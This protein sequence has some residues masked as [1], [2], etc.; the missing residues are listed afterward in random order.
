MRGGTAACQGL[1]EQL[2][3]R[4]GEGLASYEAHRLAVDTYSLQHPERYCVSAKS[5][6]AHLT[7]C[8]GPS[9]AAGIP[10][11]FGALHWWLGRQCIE[12]AME[13]R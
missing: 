13:R 3:A 10:P 6:A 1:F 5:M 8:A 2:L 9:S 11:A 4:E 7:A 12:Q